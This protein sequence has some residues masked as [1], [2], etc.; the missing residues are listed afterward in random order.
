[1]QQMVSD[2]CVE[3][4]VLDTVDQMECTSARLGPEN[5]P[6]LPDLSGQ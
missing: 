1:M 6:D 5:R 2:L 3:V 4:I